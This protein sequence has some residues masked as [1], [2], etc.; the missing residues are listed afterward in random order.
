MLKTLLKAAA[1]IA[2]LSMTGCVSYNVTGPV[3]A[4][5]HPAPVT[6]PRTAQL[7]DVV[8]SAPGIR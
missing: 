3:G 6:S 8:V 7:A 5:P 2:T 1:L 4:P